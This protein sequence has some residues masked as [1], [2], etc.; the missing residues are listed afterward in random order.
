MK[1]IEIKSELKFVFLDAAKSC[2]LEVEELKLC[3]LPGLT[4]YRITTKN[5]SMHDIFKFGVYFAEMS[6]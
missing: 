4:V 6:R 5:F 2:G 3:K 1:A